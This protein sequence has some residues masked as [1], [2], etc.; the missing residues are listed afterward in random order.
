MDP[1]NPRWETTIERDQRYQRAKVFWSVVV[2]IVAAAALTTVFVASCLNRGQVQRE[3]ASATPADPTSVTETTGAQTTIIETQ[4]QQPASGTTTIVVQQPVATVTRP[5]PA[6]VNN[7]QP[8]TEPAPRTIVRAAPQVAPPAVTVVPQQTAPAGVPPTDNTPITPTQSP[9]GNST[10][11]APSP[12]Q[13]AGPF[14]T[15]S[16]PNAASNFK[17]NPEAGAGAFP[18]AQ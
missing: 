8:S 18:G 14:T 5:A 16:P 10:E 1:K 9:Q 17:E 7:D 6:A 3:S 12:T 2:S 15:D 13:G 4:P 11:V